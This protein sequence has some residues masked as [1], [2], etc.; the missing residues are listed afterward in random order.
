MFQ[1]LQKI[2]KLKFC[3]IGIFENRQIIKRVVKISY[4]IRLAR[5]SRVT[6]A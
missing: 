4:N 6:R 2:A 3:Y 1:N 5:N